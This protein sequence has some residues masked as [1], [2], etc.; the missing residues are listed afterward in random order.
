M[1]SVEMGHAFGIKP[2]GLE[3][4]GGPTVIGNGSVQEAVSTFDLTMLDPDPRNPSRKVPFPIKRV[5]QAI[6][7]L[8]T[9]YALVS[10]SA[11]HRRF[12][13]N[14]RWPA[15]ELDKAALHHKAVALKAINLGGHLADEQGLVRFQWRFC[16]DTPL[17]PTAS[18]CL[19]LSFTLASLYRYRPNL[20]DSIESSRVNLIFDVFLNE[21]DAFL[22]PAFRNL[23]YGEILCLYRTRFT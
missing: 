7:W 1:V 14:Q 20:L 11:N 18:A 3:V 2:F 4:T 8:K 12:V 22:L 9:D 10:R 23:L 19:L 13:S 5:Y 6:P 17:L 16:P 15:T 21:A